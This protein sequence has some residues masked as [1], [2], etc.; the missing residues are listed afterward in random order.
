M[1][2]LYTSN[3]SEFLKRARRKGLAVH[4]FEDVYCEAFMRLVDAVLRGT[5]IMDA[6][7]YLARIFSNRLIDDMKKNK[8]NPEKEELTGEE[9]D[10]EQDVKLSENAVNRIWET[11]N[12]LPEKYREYIILHHMEGKSLKEIACE[13]DSKQEIVKTELSRG[14]KKFRELYNKNEDE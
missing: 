9:K 4:D 8:K 14:R 6:N 7:A 3:K 10:L 2:Y 13:F 12:N 1:A 5:K 11:I